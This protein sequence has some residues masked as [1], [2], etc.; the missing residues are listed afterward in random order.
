M[1]PEPQ[2]LTAEELFNPDGVTGGTPQH[3]A[4]VSPLKQSP[5]PRS[6]M[7]NL[8]GRQMD[9]SRN[10]RAQAKRTLSPAP[11]DPNKCAKIPT[12]ERAELARQSR[13][14]HRRHSGGTRSQSRP[15]QNKVLIPAGYE[16]TYRQE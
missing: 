5:T 10:Q 1:Q 16:S 14:K 12:R 7:Q 8:S 6:L 11:V 13:S 2:G 4:T 15:R 3:S 9:A